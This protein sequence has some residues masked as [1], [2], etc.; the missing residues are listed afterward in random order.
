MNQ[1]NIIGRAVSDPEIRYTQGGKAI[2][3]VTIAV[4]NKYKKDEAYFF[5]TQSWDKTAELIA[6]HIRKG[7]QI[8]ITGEL[9]QQTWEKEGKKQSKVIINI[10]SITFVGK[11]S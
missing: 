2:S 9:Q 7:D 4:N 5:D 1:I 11:K 8:G 3:K 6:E 10:E